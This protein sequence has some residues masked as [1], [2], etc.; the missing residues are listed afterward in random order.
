[1]RPLRAPNSSG[2]RVDPSVFTIDRDL[3]HR[4]GAARRWANLGDWTAARTYAEACEALAAR[5]GSAARLG[6]DDAVVEVACGEGEGLR[7]WLERFGVRRA[8]GIDVQEGA[9]ARARGLLA[10]VARERWDVAV[11]S[12]TDLGAIAT[13]T[14]DAVVCVDA[15]YHFDPRDAFFAEARRVLRAGGRLALTDVVLSHPRPSRIEAL[16]ARASAV[17]R[18]NLGDEAAYVA[19]LEA[20][21]FEGIVVERLDDAVLR[22][23]AAFVRRHVVAHGLRSIRGGWPK[24]LATAVA[25]DLALRGGRVHYVM[26]SAG[27][28]GTVT[29][30]FSAAR[31]AS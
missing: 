1:M 16:A 19:R 8:T 11:G 7:L 15:A 25:A 10:R 14:I 20:A 26:L 22:G 28:G 12:A 17:P 3:L 4:G 5:V 31:A 13:G 6:A 24:V 29:P 21:G 23:F 30:R 18:A 27:A 2:S 9:I